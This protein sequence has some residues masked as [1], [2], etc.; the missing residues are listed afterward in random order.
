[1]LELEQAWTWSERYAPQAEILRYMDHVV[2]RLDLRRGIPLNAHVTSAHYDEANALWAVQTA[3]GRRFEARYL[4][5][6]TGGLSI[7]QKPDLRGLDE[8]QGRWY[9]SAR[10]PSEGVDFTGQR[11]VLIGTG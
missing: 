1:C 8:F 4:V 7:P 11:V 10:W 9:H 2:D 5:M 3:D 6:A